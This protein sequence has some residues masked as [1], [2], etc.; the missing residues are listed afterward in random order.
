MN[1]FDEVNMFFNRAA[2]RLGL[3]DG[4]RELLRKPWR[5]LTVSVPVRMDDGSIKVFN[6]YRIQH[7]AARGPYRVARATT[8]PP[9][10]TRCGH[11][12]LS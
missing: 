6:G 4:T 9:M 1:A 12:H 10:S 11:W 8:P 3:D 2:D 5:E 7:N